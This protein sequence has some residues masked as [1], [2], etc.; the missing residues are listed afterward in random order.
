MIHWLIK[1][2]H[3]YMLETKYGKI[4]KWFDMAC[5]C[6]AYCMEQGIEVFYLKP[7]NRLVERRAYEYWTGKTLWWDQ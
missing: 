1:T 7:K 5:N 6:K 4:V 3:G 2:E